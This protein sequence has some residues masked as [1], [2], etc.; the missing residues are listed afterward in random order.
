[1]DRGERHA[2][3]TLDEWRMRY[4]AAPV[5]LRVRW[6]LSCLMH[7]CAVSAARHV[8]REA[9]KLRKCRDALT[10]SMMRH[11]RSEHATWSR[12]WRGER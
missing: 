12:I 1:M 10:G 2:P 9:R 6:L 4:D 8:D 11:A 3:D 7:L 5:A